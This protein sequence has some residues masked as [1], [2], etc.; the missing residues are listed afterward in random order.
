M[1]LQVP[2]WTNCYPCFRQEALT[3]SICEKDANIALLQMS[4]ANNAHAQQAMQKLM[5]EKS[6]MQSQL[7]QLVSLSHH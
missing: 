1:K 6:Q 7:K 4:G 2:L 3:A 5:N